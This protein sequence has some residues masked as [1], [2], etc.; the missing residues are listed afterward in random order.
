MLTASSLFLHSLSEA[1]ITHAFV[2]WGSDHPA[3]L[4][5][6]QRQCAKNDGRTTIEIVTCPNEMVALSAAQGYAQVAG[7]LAAVILHV[8]V[9]TQ[10]LAGAIHNVDRSRTPV[11]IFAG[12]SA[13]SSE[14]EHRGT[15]NEWIVW[16]QDIPDQSAIVR[17]YMRYTSQFHSGATIPQVVR[18]SLQIAMSEP[19]GPV[20]LWARR[21][22]MEEEISES[23]LKKSYTLDKWPAVQP[24]ALSS[25]AVARVAAALHAATSPLIITSFL[26]RNKRAVESLVTLST[27]LAIPVVSTCPSNVNIPFSHPNFAGVTYLAPNTHTEHLSKADVIL[28]VDCDLPYIPAN[29][30][31]EASARVFIIDLGDP[32]KLN[33]GQWHA[34]AEMV[35]RAD[36][37]LALNQILD[38]ITGIDEQEKCVGQSVLGGPLVRER[39]RMLEAKH[40]EWTEALDALEITYPDPVKALSTVEG[41]VATF[42]VPNIMSLLRQAIHDQTPSRGKDVLYLNEAISSYGAVW[43]HLRPDVPGSVITSG[44]SSLGWAL[45]A[46]VGA[47][48]GASVMTGGKGHELIVA[49]VGDGSF[50][51]G[52]PGTAYWLARKY[53]TPFLTIILNNGGWKSPK[54]SMLS[55]HPTGYG[56]QAPGQNLSVGFG[57]TCPDYSQ[58]AV[59]ASG[60]GW[61]WG[62]RIGG[63]HP[64]QAK[65]RLK[66][67]ISEAVRV[68]V[69][70]KRCAV[71][72]CV[73]ESL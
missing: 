60:D 46:A 55:V 29:N 33:V 14:R 11:L 64:D 49:I 68:V 72:D 58:I 65:E 47:Y 36:A 48:M 8:D 57:P 40:R 19:K 69:E 42:T 53:N 54:L 3:L 30:S 51:F 44:G 16:L 12:A 37:E 52:V 59:A 21:E 24:T 43:T 32:L 50:L 38:A 73:I 34:D 31:P 7:R 13:F 2:N 15:R 61:A 45:G 41:E 6:L 26:G 63:G 62:Q 67:V 5:E 1:G 20:Y 27:T 28:I 39:N 71:V 22:V 10:A 56:S 66:Q 4:E 18:R 9:G 23:L 70:E 35:C 25:T 17:Q